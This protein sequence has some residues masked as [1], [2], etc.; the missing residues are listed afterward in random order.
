ML[1]HMHSVSNAKRGSIVVGGFITS[2]NH[3]LH[4][5]AELAKLVL[6][7]GSTIL[8]LHAYRSRWLIKYKKEGGYY[9][10]LIIILLGVLTFISLHALMCKLR[11]IDYMI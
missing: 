1:A 8:D 6:I 2:I 11:G 4:L 3:A 7:L 5:K 9:L 10:L